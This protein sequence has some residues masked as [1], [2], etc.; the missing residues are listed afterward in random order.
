MIIDTDEVIIDEVVEEN[1]STQVGAYEGLKRVDFHD[2]FSILNYGKEVLDE[3]TALA[4][5]V[6]ELK[7]SKESE[8]VALNNKKINELISFKQYFDAQ[9]Q[10][11]KDLENDEIKREKLT[12]LLSRIPLL[13]NR[14]HSLPLISS[15]KNKE[16]YEIMESTNE[17]YKR[18]VE[19][20]G[21][22]ANDVKQTEL[23]HL[24]GMKMDSSFKKK[25]EP[26]IKKLDWLIEIGYQDKAS[27]EQGELA[28]LEQA[29]QANPEDLDCQYK[30]KLAKQTVSIFDR[31]LVDLQGSAARFKQQIQEMGLSQ[32][33]SAEIITNCESFLSTTMP[34]LQIQA[35][36]VVSIHRQKEDIER[37]QA[38][39]TAANTAMAENS[40]TLVGNLEKAKELSIK[41]NVFDETL[42]KLRDN[43]RKGLNL[44]EHWESEGE[45]AKEKTRA[46]VEEI[47]QSHKAEQEVIDNMIQGREVAVSFY[48]EPTSKSPYRKK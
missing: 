46:L 25:L 15:K 44:I 9:E 31:K 24:E 21:M 37:Q 19:G 32:I 34:L 11:K 47:N 1:E 8:H 26:W 6:A 43:I 41:G 12:G 28:K 40:D 29:Y 36:N 33:A 35:V 42:E 16:E 13:G 20:L 27:F 45:K 39:V 22:I 30:L 4:N 2:T 17:Q 38:I 23:D 48:E 14:V 10:K 7:G 5:G 18:Y 3:M